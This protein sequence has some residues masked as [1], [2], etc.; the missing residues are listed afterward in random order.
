MPIQIK[1]NP[2]ETSQNL[3]RRFSRRIQQSGVLRRARN[4][5]FTKRS[6]SEQLKKKTAL[7]KQELKKEYQV[8]EKL[9]KEPEKRGRRY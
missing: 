8:L 6:K 2:R 3:V 1:K 4:I 5:R 9:G 7:R